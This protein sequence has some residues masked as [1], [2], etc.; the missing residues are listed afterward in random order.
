MV[1]GRRAPEHEGVLVSTCG[2][3][4]RDSS[5]EGVKWLRAPGFSL[6]S[7]LRNVLGFF[8]FPVCVF[9]SVCCFFFVCF[10]FVFSPQ[11]SIVPLSA[12]E[13]S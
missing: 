12:R 6:M 1:F 7:Q 10:C 5:F 11:R 2:Y 3:N 8:V 4:T 13:I 9:V